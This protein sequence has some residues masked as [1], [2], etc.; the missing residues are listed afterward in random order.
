MKFWD[1][2]AIVPLLT[3]EAASSLRLRQAEDDGGML[4]WWATPVECLSAVRRAVREGKLA[5][6]DALIATGHLRELEGHWTEIEPTQQ[7]RQQAERLLR[8]HSLRAA[9]ALQLAA[10]VIGSDYEPNGMSFLTGDT[11]LAEAATK[12][13]FKVE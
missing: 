9:D 11:R 5:E 8:T 12:E 4:V 7:V 6:R 3:N 1:A 13:G 2:S 10:A